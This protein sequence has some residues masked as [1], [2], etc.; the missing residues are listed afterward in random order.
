MLKAAGFDATVRE[1]GSRDL[2]LQALSRAPR[3]RRSPSTSPTVTEFINEQATANAT[4][5][6]SG[7][8]AGDRSARCKPLADKA[9]LT[10]GDPSQA[11]DQNAFAVTK[12]FADKLG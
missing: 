4:P 5:V 1:V 7:D 12:E 8:V 11:A 3:S 9:G 10:F 2:Y 6:A